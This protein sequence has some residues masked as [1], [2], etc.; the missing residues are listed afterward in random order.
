MTPNTNPPRSIDPLRFVSKALIRLK[1]AQSF[2]DLSKYIP[3]FKKPDGSRL[4]TQRWQILA[5]GLLLTEFSVVVVRYT[6]EPSSRML[7]SVSERT[8][9]D[10]AKIA[11]LV[12]VRILSDSGSGSGV[13][14]RRVGETYTVLTN[15]HVV[16]DTSTQNYKILTADG[17][18][19]VAKKVKSL[20]E[21]QLDVALVEFTSSQG[22]HMVEM[23]NSQR[24]R[25][26][27][28]VYAA[29]F[30]NWRWVKVKE[31]EN[32]R[33]LGLQAFQ[34]TEGKVGMLPQQSMQEGYQLGYTNEIAQ[35]MSG[36]P[37]LN[38]WGKL[39]GINGRSK[40]PLA[41]IDAFEFV[42]GSLPTQHG[43]R[44]M[45]A[46]SWGIPVGVFGGRVD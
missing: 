5:L 43:F 29:G 26:G 7:A 8:N 34:L 13:I 44:K 14:V 6:I 15:D 21:S 28:K 11:H 36:G 39:V 41:G 46:L 22:Y 18:T 45:E 25:L 2:R 10:V 31:I 24:L 30:P 16:A 23:E 20:Q 42:D 38:I 3:T 1:N 9:I 4:W 35:G 33:K 19:H 40:Y 27:D 32:T 37:V 17:K 12:T